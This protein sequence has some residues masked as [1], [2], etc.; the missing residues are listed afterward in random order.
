M[1][2]KQ[3]V[4]PSSST[5]GSSLCL[6]RSFMLFCPFFLNEEEEEEELGEEDSTVRFVCWGNEKMCGAVS[7]NEGKGGIESSTRGEKSED[8]CGVK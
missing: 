3:G 4:F 7:S 2:R 6:S 5:T 8:M 1:K